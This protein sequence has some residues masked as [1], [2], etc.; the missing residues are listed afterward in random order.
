[1]LG[2]K[3]RQDWK[4]KYRTLLNEVEAK[5][6]SWEALEDELRIAAA[7][8][9]IAAMGQDPNIDSSLE[10]IH[11]TIKSRAGGPELGP[12]L[13]DLS[14]AVSA[15]EKNKVNHNSL[16]L[17]GFVAELELP[18]AD[19]HRFI[20]GLESDEHLN[21]VQTLKELAGELNRL[22]E[23]SSQ[24]EESTEAVVRSVLD[25]LVKHIREVPALGEAINNFERLIRNG[26]DLD[27]L[28]ASL[29]SLAESITSIIDTLEQDRSELEAFLEQIT[30]QLEQFESWSVWQQ[31]DSQG[32]KKDSDEFGSNVEIQVDELHADIEASTEL[33][34]LKTRVQVRLDSI[35]DQL[36]DFR[37]RETE[38][39][40]QAESRNAVLKDE[41]NRLKVRTSQLAQR[42]GDQE[43]R[44]MF[45][46]LTGVHSRYAYDKRLQEEF[47]RWQR[48]DHPLVFSIWDIDFFK[49]VNDSCGH[50]VGDRLLKAIA[51]LLDEQ[52]RIEDFVAR[53][54]G[55]EFVVLFPSTQLEPAEML[56]NRLREMIANAVFQH[57]GGQLQITVSCGL[58]EFQEG[59]TPKVVHE[60]ADKALY[61]AKNS[62]RNR[63]VTLQAE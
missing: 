34:D 28:D 29:G 43:S 6:V 4:V 59:D 32:R 17:S 60:R 47:Q 5:Q 16:D 52:S 45:D 15:H 36:Q 24:S 63:C 31:D 20:E 53:V 22:L 41:I 49:S 46:T 42:C 2:T 8:L 38:R 55:E 12:Q 26:E 13:E 35:A 21:R 62:G 56:A 39:L 19:L 50:Q 48:H 9:A 10:A 54:G 33:G 3:D 37:E 7:R 18:H 40:N 27:N 11:R 44:L 51:G 23:A 57:K 61:Q 30:K 25:R 1:M 58:T 14:S